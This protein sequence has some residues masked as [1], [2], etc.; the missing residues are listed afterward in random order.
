MDFRGIIRA[1]WVNLRSGRV[2]QGGSTIT[3]QVAKSFL[4]PERTV[5][6]KLKE[7]VLARRI[8]ARYTK[9]QILYL[10]LNHIYFGAKSYGVKACGANLLRQEAQ[11][12]RA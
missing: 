11:S 3:Q 1:A 6:R 5:S 12:A 9:A 8:E 4:T 2:R 7:L 10:Y